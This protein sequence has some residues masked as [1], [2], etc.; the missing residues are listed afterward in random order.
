MNFGRKHGRGAESTGASGFGRRQGHLVRCFV[1]IPL[2]EPVQ[3]G[4]M[5]LKG[6][7]PGEETL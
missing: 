4:A 3:P 1:A 5:S 7:A 2:P 6:H